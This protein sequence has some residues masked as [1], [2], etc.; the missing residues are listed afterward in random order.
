MIQ[1]SVSFMFCKRV[2]DLFLTLTLTLTL[3]LTLTLHNRLHNLEFFLHTGH[4]PT[5]DVV[6]ESAPSTWI[7][8]DTR[9]KL[10]VQILQTR[11]ESCIE[12]IINSLIQV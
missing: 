3:I 11:S 9:F 4:Y 8:Q 2:H 5:L 10:K 7:G 6:E 12:I 1:S